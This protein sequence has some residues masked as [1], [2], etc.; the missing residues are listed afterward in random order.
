MINGD[1]GAMIYVT[2]H[3]YFMAALT[4]I[5]SGFMRYHLQSKTPR[6]SHR[7]HASKPY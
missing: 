3:M 2:M 6:T 1:V 7:P 5:D 4:T